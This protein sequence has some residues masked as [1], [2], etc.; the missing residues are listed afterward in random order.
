MGGFAGYHD[1]PSQGLRVLTGHKINPVNDALQVEVLDEPGVGG[2]CHEYLITTPPPHGQAFAISFQ[3]GPIAEAGVNGIT[4]EALLAILI[5]RLE[6]FQAGPYANDYN[7]VALTHQRSIRVMN[8]DEKR[9]LETYTKD[10]GKLLIEKKK[11]TDRINELVADAADKLKLRK[12]NVRNAAKER[13][14]S[15]LER[16]DRRAVEEE[17]DQIRNALGIL[18]DTPLGEAAAKKGGTSKQV[19]KIAEQ[20]GATI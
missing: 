9:K 10:I 7:A 15:E 19:K 8:Q 1:N 18:A 13:N 17:M 14:M 2:A 4:H 20:T 12:G 16:A 11:L 3:H 6:H 5:D